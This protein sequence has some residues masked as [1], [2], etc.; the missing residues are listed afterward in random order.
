[1]YA[2]ESCLMAVR[3]F[4]T[5]DAYIHWMQQLV[6]Y[7]NLV[8]KMCILKEAANTFTKYITFATPIN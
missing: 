8:P 3:A 7:E 2:A 4:L 1:M 6:N 5:V